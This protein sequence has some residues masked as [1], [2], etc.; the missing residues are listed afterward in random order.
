MS[1]RQWCLENQ[2][3]YSTYL[4]WTRKLRSAAESGQKVIPEDPVFAQLPSEQEY[5]QLSLF[6][7]AEEAADPDAVEPAMEGNARKNQL[8]S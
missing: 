4:Y 1:A 3:S 8:R 5:E 7:E 2:I 6:N